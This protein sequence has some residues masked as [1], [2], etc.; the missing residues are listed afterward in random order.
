MVKYSTKF[1]EK[2]FNKKIGNVTSHLYEGEELLFFGPCAKS[3]SAVNYVAIT[4]MRIISL[5]DGQ[6]KMSLMLGDVESIMPGSGNKKFL[7]AMK[8]GERIT[9]VASS[10]EDCDAIISTFNGAVG[11]QSHLGDAVAHATA[12]EKK[13]TDAELGIWED[14][15]VKGRLTKVASKA[16]YRQCSQGESPWF[17]LCPGAGMG[18]LAAFDNRLVIIKTGALTGFMAGSLGGERAA[19]F[20]YSQVTGVEYNSGMMNGVLEVLTP[21]YD[22]S[23]NKDYW[24]G[25]LDSRNA[26]SNDPWT[27]SN[28]LPLPKAE[29]TAALPHL[30]ELRERIAMAKTPTVIVEVPEAKA[31]PAT[32]TLADEIKQ[33]SELMEAGV[34]SSEEFAQA[35]AKLIGG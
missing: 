13:R 25:A 28:C 7:L 9:L 18:L 4:T 31:V 17:I 1:T 23:N 2:K 21:S 12:N 32:S 22:G 30:T 8:D 19:V 26:D 16:I 10:A 27:L 29:Y 14:T 15:V 6:V 20:H 3:F 33:L 11:S 5:F 24:R 34:L 35:K